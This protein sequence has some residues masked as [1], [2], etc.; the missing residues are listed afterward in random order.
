MHPECGK[1]FLLPKEYASFCQSLPAAPF[2][3]GCCVLGDLTF[4]SQGGLPFD[5][6]EPM[7]LAI[8]WPLSGMT[9]Q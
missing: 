7:S 8:L 3:R 5:L 2:A 1:L 9:G 4:E 6:T